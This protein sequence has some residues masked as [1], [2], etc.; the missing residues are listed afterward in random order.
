MTAF[1]QKRVQITKKYDAAFAKFKN[2]A[3]IQ[4]KTREIS[5]TTFMWPKVDFEKL[6]KSVIK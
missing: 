1:H 5:E 2:L 4:H 3:R 6:K